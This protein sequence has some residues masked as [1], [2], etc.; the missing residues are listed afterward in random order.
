MGEIKSNGLKNF[1]IG[2]GCGL[3][4]GVAIG[5]LFAPQEGAKTR[6]LIKDKVVETKKQA[7]ITV[8]TI[9][10]KFSKK[11]TDTDKVHLS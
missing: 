10:D 2:L 5:I 8:A 3:L 11:K 6:K 9:K 4:I 7:K 1:G